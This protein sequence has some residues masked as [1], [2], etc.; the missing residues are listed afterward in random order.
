MSRRLRSASVRRLL[1]LLASDGDVASTLVYI[2]DGKPLVVSRHSTDPDARHGRGAGG[3]DKGYKLHLIS[4]LHGRV[5]MTRV[6]PL[7]TPEPE[8]ARR[9]IKSGRLGGGYVLGDTLY[10]WDTLHR[11]CAGRGLRLLVHRR[12]SRARRG[13]R[14]RGVSPA[15]L[16]CIASTETPTAVFAPALLGQ[17]RVIEGVFARLETRWRI[18]HPPAHVRTLPRVRCWTQAALILDRFVQDARRFQS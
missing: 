2:V 15:R 1:D 10:D 9:M 17:R 13:M 4:D 6:T 3:M 11:E 18:G 5:H 14:W 8:M 16:A 12:P 7:N